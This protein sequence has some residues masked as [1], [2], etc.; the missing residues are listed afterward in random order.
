LEKSRAKRPQT[1]RELSQLIARCA[2][3]TQWS[4][5]EADA[6]WGRHERGHPNAPTLAAPPVAP[7]GARRTAAQ[8]HD[9]T[10]DHGS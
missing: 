1:A 2:E 8:G 5:E 7:A 9:V 6:W 10:M 4:V 3:V